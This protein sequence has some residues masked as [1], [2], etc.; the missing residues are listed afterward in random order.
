MEAKEIEFDSLVK[1]GVKYRRRNRRRG[2]RLW[3]DADEIKEIDM[4]ANKREKREG[5]RDE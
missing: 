3:G 2:E 4:K 5:R 1:E